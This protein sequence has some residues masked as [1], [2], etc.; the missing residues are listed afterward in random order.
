MDKRLFWGSVPVLIILSC[1]ITAGCTGTSVSAKNVTD[2]NNRFAF[3]Y[4]SLLA[5]DPTNGESNIFFSPF[6]LSSAFAITCDGARG[7]TADEIRSVF[8]F[9]KDDA[10]RRQEFA[11]ISAIMNRNDNTTHLYSANAL[12]AEKTY[13]FLPEYISTAQQYYAAN[14]TN[15]DF[16]NNADDSRNRINTWVEERTN[17]KI[18]DFIRSGGINPSTRLVI[19]NAI[20]FNG[21]WEKPFDEGETD[22]YQF[23]ITPGKTVRVP[24]MQRGDTFAYTETSRI[25][26][27]E[28]PYKHG[29]GKDLSMIVILPKHETLVGVENSLN[30][31]MLSDLEHKLN[32]T[33]MVVSLPKFKLETRYELPKALKTMGMPTAFAPGADFS[34]MDGTKRLFIDNVVHKAFIEVDEE[35]TEAAAASGVYLT[36][37]SDYSPVFR[38]D[39]PFLFLIQDK[40]T[41]T[42]LFLGR[43][44]NP[45]TNN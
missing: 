24:M 6:S 14:V 3:D 18:R 23:S 43:V 31:E 4:Y 12:W 27:I 16:I 15:L 34:G 33:K 37:S 32:D 11:N 5:N 10:A 20:Y 36:M 42:I 29:N 38:A 41:G 2:A 30:G 22:E 25:Q 1:L 44:V 21:K 45:N 9:P 35:G 19:T 7:D 26:M 39:H 28:L 13:P 8:H 17:N 40:E